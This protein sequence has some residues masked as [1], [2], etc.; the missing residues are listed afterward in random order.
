MT[1]FLDTAKIDEI[2]A[3]MDFGVIRGITTNQSIF[4]QSG[5]KYSK[6]AYM[7][8]IERI[9]NIVQGPVSV[10]LTNSEGS[11][12]DL[13]HEAEDLHDIDRVHIIIK[14]PMWNTGKGLTLIS[15]LTAKDILVNATCLISASQA[16]LAMEAGARYVSLFYNRIL[17]YYKAHVAD[18]MTVEDVFRL[19]HIYLME[20]GGNW[21]PPTEIIAGSIRSPND[22]PLAFSYGADIVTVKYSTL[23]EMIKHPKTDETINEFDKSWAS[24]INGENVK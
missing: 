15:E 2:E 9:C 1:L 7:A 21:D 12:D 17:D 8:A 11:V 10:E 4:M 13:I 14:V 20:H 6:N 23:Q 24:F 19:S 18:A 22:V 16:I 3:A 5:M